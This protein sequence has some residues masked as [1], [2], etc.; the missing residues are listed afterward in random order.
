VQASTRVATDFSARAGMG[1]QGLTRAGIHGHTS[2]ARTDTNMKG[3]AETRG[4]MQKKTV[5]QRSSKIPDPI[6]NPNPEALPL[7]IKKPQFTKRGMG[8]SATLEEKTGIAEER[9]SH[10]G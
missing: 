8:G 5:L 3:T 9:I 10:V 1:G 7:V 4:K 2:R 6:V